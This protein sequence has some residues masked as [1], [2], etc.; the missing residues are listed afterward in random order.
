[1][2]HLTGQV[3]VVSGASRG[4]GRAIALALGE[5]GATV[6]VTGRTE[7]G[8]HNPDGRSETFEDTAEMVTAKGGVGIAVRCDHTREEDIRALFARI[9]EE[10]GTLDILVNNAWG[11]YEAYGSDFDYP[12]WEQPL[13]R[14]HRMLNAGLN[15]HMMTTALGIPM[16]L[17]RNKGLVILTTTNVEKYYNSVFYDTVKTAINRMPF[18]MNADLRSKGYDGV[19]VLALAPGFMRTE[20]VLDTFDRGEKDWQEQ[21]ELSKTESPQYIGRAIVALATDTK[22]AEKS[23]GLYQVGNLAQEYGF[24]DYDGRY[25]PP[26]KA[27]E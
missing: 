10:Q 22:V 15:S 5:A 24:T 16:M 27:E 7:R 20:A 21:P 17:E 19:T 12:F 25:V 4:G 11:G 18:G 13:S 23:G 3:A 14:W 8:G 9:R 26:F 2:T 6:Y 1:M